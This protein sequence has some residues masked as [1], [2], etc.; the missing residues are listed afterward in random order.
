MRRILK[1]LTS[2]A[3]ICIPLA[4]IQLGVLVLLV[5]RVALAY[6]FLPV[7]DALAVI[8]SIYIINRNE[9]PSYKIAWCCLVLALPVVGVPLYLLAGNRKIPRKLVDGTIRGTM[10]TNGFLDG[11]G[12]QN[13]R[14]MGEED[15]KLFEYGADRLGFPVYENSSCEYYKSGED[16]FPDYLAELEKAEHF[17]FMEFYIIDQGSCLDELT[18]ILERKA[19]EGV[20]VILIYDD[21]GCVTMPRRFWRKL[22][23]KGIK[24]YAFNKIRPAFIIQMNN[25]DHRKITI[26]DNKTAFVGGVNIADEYV[27]RISRFGYWKDSALKLKGDAV[28]SLTVMFLGMYTNVKNG[29]EEIDYAKYRL[30]HPCEGD[31]GKYQP[32]SDSPTDDEPA[33]LFYHMNLINQ[34]EK[35]IY[36]DTPYL[37]LNTSVQSSLMLAA[38]NGVDVRIMTPYIPDK[39]LVNQITKANYLPLLKSGVKIYEYLPGFDHAKNFVSD[40]K[41]AIVGSSNMDYRSYFLHFENGVLFSDSPEIVK[42]RDDFLAAAEQAREITVTEVEKTALPVKLARAVLNMF[43]P[44]V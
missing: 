44:L 5:Y 11:E 38:K 39:I 3:M 19:A 32:Y 23:E 9:D 15:R 21:F 2:K 40:D 18:A 7:M 37:I 28:W 12:R 13:L 4:F 1:F 14:S 42:I 24:A 29:E 8:L 16:W 31:G 22:K 27:N 41:A 30:S 20:E 26:I 35:Y 43:I 17:I 36:M 6:Q 25:R 33:A 34:A 10:K